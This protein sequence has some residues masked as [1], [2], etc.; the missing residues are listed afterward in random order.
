MQK[1]NKT[2][3]RGKKKNRSCDDIYT[4]ICYLL[5]GVHCFELVLGKKKSSAKTNNKKKKYFVDQF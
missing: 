4:G 1:K 3:R 2:K 5:N